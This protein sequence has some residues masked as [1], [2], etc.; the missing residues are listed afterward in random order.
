MTCLGVGVRQTPSH[1]RKLGAH[2]MR[3]LMLLRARIGSTNKSTKDIEELKN[4]N[5]GK[6][7][8]FYSGG[9]FSVLKNLMPTQPMCLIG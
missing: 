1:I 2:R 7:E 3:S 9:I 5:E 6:E 8:A 4:L